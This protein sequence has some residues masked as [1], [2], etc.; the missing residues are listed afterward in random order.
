MTASLVGA[1]GRRKW[2]LT[3][4]REGHRDYLLVSL[5][6]TTDN[7]DGPATVL[8]TPGLPAVGD[9]WTYGN[10]IDGFALCHPDVRITPTRHDEPHRLWIVENHFRTLPMERCQDTPIEDPLLEP[11]KIS[12]SFI[13]FTRE[14]TRDRFGNFILSSSHE[15]IRGPQVE[16]DDSRAQVRIT[17][18]V[19]DLQLPTLTQF[20]DTVNDAPLWGLPKRTIKLSEPTFER[21]YRGICEIYYTRTLT[22]DIDFNTFDRKALDEGT[23]VLK[24]RWSAG[25]VAGSVWT[26][27]FGVDPNDV[28]DFMKFVDCA[29]NPIE[30]VILNGAGEPITSPLG[31]GIGAGGA[32][33]AYIQVEKYAES[34]FLLLNIPTTL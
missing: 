8:A 23:R 12:G 29:G 11:D 3:R 28:S 24:G 2:S 13:R 1:E 5:V 18:N 7:D 19:S 6:K 15:L 30:N 31:T 14:A 34:N 16:F 4:D 10:D 26:T 22:F 20:V 32:G 17:Q 25:C 21:R 9:S 33:P 27:N